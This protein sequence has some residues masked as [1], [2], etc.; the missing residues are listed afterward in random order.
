MH[1]L[2]IHHIQSTYTPSL[3][4]LRDHSLFLGRRFL[5][6][7]FTDSLLLVWMVITLLPIR[8]CN[9]H[10][11]LSTLQI[12]G[13]CMTPYWILRLSKLRDWF[14]SV[15]CHVPMPPQLIC[16]ICHGVRNSR[17]KLGGEDSY[18]SSQLNIRGP[19][20]LVRG[21]PV[22]EPAEQLTPAKVLVEARVVHPQSEVTFEARDKYRK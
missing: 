16:L 12:Y 20:Y 11:S 4:S 19:Q 14:C 17:L 13:K 21:Y 6:P 9:D 1:H 7:G 22:V 15:D 10:Q 2:W 18:P 8:S 3:P 5:G